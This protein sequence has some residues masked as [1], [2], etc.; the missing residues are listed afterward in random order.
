MLRN[1]G[2]HWQESFS[3][4]VGAAVFEGSR[5]GREG[6]RRGAQFSVSEVQGQMSI[7]AQQEQFAQGVAAGKSHAE[8]YRAAYPKALNW[9]AKTAA[10]NAYKLTSNPKISDRI[11]QIRAELADRGMW[12]REQSVMAL[13]KV[14]EAP[15]KA[16]DV[17][18]AVKELNA[19]HGYNEPL[20]VDHRGEVGVITRRIVG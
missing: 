8:A 18:A 5:A 2:R 1:P 19:M 14:V 16:S 17:V 6:S 13:V 4:V 7:T 10:N 11:K 20:K 15:D 9:S 3:G 12:S